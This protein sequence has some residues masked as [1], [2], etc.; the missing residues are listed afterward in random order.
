M[1]LV[2]GTVTQECLVQLPDM[3]FGQMQILIGLEHQVHGFGI[4]RN[5]LFVAGCE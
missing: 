4:A 3:V 2:F 5:L 1:A